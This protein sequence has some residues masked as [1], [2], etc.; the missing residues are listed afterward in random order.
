M[1]KMKFVAMSGLMLGMGIALN[2]A[3]EAKPMPAPVM[4]QGG[5]QA[6]IPVAKAFD[7][8]PDT[9]ATVGGKAVTTL[10]FT[11]V[12]QRTDS[13][14]FKMVYRKRRKFNEEP[15]CAT[16]YDSSDIK[17]QNNM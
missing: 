12:V 17:R 10:S 8:L 6:T 4:N 14:M 15:K 11:L 2:A 9:I 1:K 13:P 5:Q 7:F 16:A 3:D